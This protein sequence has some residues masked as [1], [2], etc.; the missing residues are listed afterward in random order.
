VGAVDGVVQ[1]AA[2]DPVARLEQDDLVPTPGQVA[3]SGQTGKT[4]AD[5]HDICGRDPGCGSGVHGLVER[6][7]R[8]GGAGD[9]QESAARV[10]PQGRW[11]WVGHRLSSWCT[12]SAKTAVCR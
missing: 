9:G 4:G 2:A 11:E 10:L 1:G 7:T 12:R 3:S 8:G 6:Q 5:H